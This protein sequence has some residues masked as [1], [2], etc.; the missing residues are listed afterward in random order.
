[1]SAHR[2]G[3]R[4][5]AVGL[6]GVDLALACLPHASGVDEALHRSTLDFDHALRGF[7]GLNR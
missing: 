2:L 1:L 5:P 4:P 7:R 6:G 3:R